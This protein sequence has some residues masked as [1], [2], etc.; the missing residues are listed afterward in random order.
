MVTN[1]DI[2][3][4]LVGHLHYE[5]AEVLGWTDT[6]FSRLLRTE[7]TPQWKLAILA[8]IAKLDATA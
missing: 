4:A 5:V 2:R 8:A 7:L 1:K 3:M 6:K